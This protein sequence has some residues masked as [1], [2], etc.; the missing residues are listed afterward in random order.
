MRRQSLRLFGRC[1]V[2]RQWRTGADQHEGRQGSEMEWPHPR[3]QY[4]QHLRFYHRHE[5][6]GYAARAGLRLRRH[7]LRRPDLEPGQLTDH[8]TWLTR[9][10]APP[11][12]RGLFILCPGSLVGQ[13]LRE[14]SHLRR[15]GVT[16]ITSARA[17]RTQYPCIETRKGISSWARLARPSSPRP[18]RSL[19]PFHSPPR[20]RPPRSTVNGASTSLLP[21]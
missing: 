7:V 3:S 14:P 8:P 19:R 15:F 9:P 18:S 20:P 5:G 16:A 12:V 1:Q 13:D 4:R 21:A 6:S 2:E 17:D 10:K 11:V